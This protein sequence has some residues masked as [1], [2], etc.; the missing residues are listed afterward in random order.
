MTTTPEP[1]LP[2]RQ[3]PNLVELAEVVDLEARRRPPADVDGI[4]SALVTL[5][6][7]G[8]AI[9]ARSSVILVADPELVL[10]GQRVEYLAGRVFE[11]IFEAPVGTPVEEL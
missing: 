6:D 11:L 9:T 7:L 5:V 3:D 2:A 4:A 8:R 10:A 1:L